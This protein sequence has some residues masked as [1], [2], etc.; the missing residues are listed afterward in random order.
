MLCNQVTLSCRSRLPYME[1]AMDETLRILTL[2]P[3]LPHATMVDTSI[4]GYKIKADTK[5]SSAMM[6]WQLEKC[7]ITSHRRDCLTKN[8]NDAV[9]T[10]VNSN[11]PF[12]YSSTCGLSITIW[13]P[14]QIRIHSDRSAFWMTT[15]T[16]FHEITLFAKGQSCAW[17]MPLGHR[18]GS[19]LTIND[20]RT[21]I[22]PQQM[23]DDVASNVSQSV[24]RSID[25]SVGRSV[26]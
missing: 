24:G 19:L 1:S 9:R 15:E 11:T 23:M 4:G 16:V 20:N 2:V 10:W 18:L 26:S 13:K 7:T 21:Y 22:D 12:R 5:V 8:K 6:R 3:I 17:F 25:R 14:I